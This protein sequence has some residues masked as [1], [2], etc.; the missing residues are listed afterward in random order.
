MNGVRRGAEWT[1]RPPRLCHV[2]SNGAT[3][4]VEPTIFADVSNRA[5]IAREEIFGPVLAII[6]YRDEEEAI[7]IANDSEYGLAGTVWSADST[8]AQQ[9][10]RRVQ[11]GTIGINGYGLD[12]AA[13]F[14]GVK[15]SGLGRE[16]G[17]ESLAEYQ[18]LKSIYLIS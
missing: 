18:L 11:T 6:P 12:P 5:A 15:A 17:P 10:A 3:P 2:R 14:G 13:P 7:Q 9:V 16:M 8:R 4:F 1:H